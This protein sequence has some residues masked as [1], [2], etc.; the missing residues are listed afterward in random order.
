MD[1]H[2]VKNANLFHLSQEKKHM[3]KFEVQ[4]T[5]WK[6]NMEPKNHPFWKEMIFQ[7]STILFHVN[8]EGCS[9]S[10][11]M[12]VDFNDKAGLIQSQ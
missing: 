1:L 7:N 6:I 12:F 9:T 2:F 3:R 11:G 10:Q 8:F 4:D 5:P